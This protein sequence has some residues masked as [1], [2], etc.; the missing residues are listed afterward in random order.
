M[1]FTQWR[2]W[3]AF[4]NAKKKSQEFLPA[5]EF[6][7]KPSHAGLRQML[8]QGIHTEPKK[9]E[10]RL[11]VLLFSHKLAQHSINYVTKKDAPPDPEVHSHA[12]YFLHFSR[13]CKTGSSGHH[14]RNSFMIFLPCFSS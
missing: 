8:L 10:T 3:E 1:A 13:R 6:M 9:E 14:L 7:R 5:E 2:R 4:S 12:S 11:Y